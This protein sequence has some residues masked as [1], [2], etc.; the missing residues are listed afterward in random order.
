MAPPSPSSDAIDGFTS[1]MSKQ[2]LSAQNLSSETLADRPSWLRNSPMGRSNQRRRREA[3]NLQGKVGNF[4]LPPTKSCRRSPEFTD[5]AGNETGGG[6]SRPKSTL[7]GFG[8]DA[9]PN[10]ARSLSLSLSP[11]PPGFPPFSPAAFYTGDGCPSVF[12]RE[13][14]YACDVSGIHAM[15]DHAHNHSQ[16][17]QDACSQ[18]H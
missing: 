10:P 9:A 7:Q 8:I 16:L 4:S 18:P 3:S 15:A 14:G 6:G 2:H 17:P 5:Q 12:A 1:S 11:P 13:N